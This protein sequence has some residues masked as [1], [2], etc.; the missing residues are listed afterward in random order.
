[1]SK[2]RYYPEALC[3][4]MAY[5][6]LRAVG[7]RAS[8]SLCGW[9]AEHLGPHTRVH[10]VAKR[11]LSIAFPDMSADERRRTLLRMWNNLGRVFGEYPFLGS[12]AL[13]Q[14]VRVEGWEHVEQALAQSQAEQRPILFVSAHL[15]NWELLP[16]VAARR[17]VP[18]HLMY[19]PAN[20]PVV[21]RLVA[22][23]RQPFSLGLHAKGKVAAKHVIEAMKRLE[24]VGML[25]DQ[26]TNDGIPVP[27]FG[28]DAMTSPAVAQFMLRR[29]AIILP[30]RCMRHEGVAFTIE[31][32]SPTPYLEVSGRT[33]HQTDIMKSVHQTLEDWIRQDLAQWF[34]VQKR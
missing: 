5:A 29:N 22:W 11:N 13:L 23:L 21:D 2:L 19:H 15:G 24:P 26:K 9:V 17:G 20:N 32:T 28:H 25:I 12:D 27:F 3:T 10:G 31:I 30:S 6:L 34:W 33:Q 14:A 4:L 8:S 16:P 1:M 7:L 18:M